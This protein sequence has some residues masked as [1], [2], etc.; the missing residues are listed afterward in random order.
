MVRSPHCGAMG[1][2]VS[3][4]YQHAGGLKDLALPLLRHRSQLQLGS[5]PWPENSI[6][7]RAAKKKRKSKEKE[8]GKK[9]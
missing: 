7:H 3:L 1:S 5:D 2:A 4:Q 8:N 6:C 9:S